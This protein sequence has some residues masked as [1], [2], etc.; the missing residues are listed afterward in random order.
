MKK[1]FII[2]LSL[3]L[4]SSSVG[5]AKSQPTSEESYL[6]NQSKANEFY[7]KLISWY[8]DQK[9][10]VEF[11]LFYGGCYLDDFGKLVIL[12]TEFTAENKQTIC[13]IIG[14][15]EVS[16]KKADYPYEHLKAAYRKTLALFGESFKDNDDV[17][18]LTKNISEAYIDEMN[19]RFVIGVISDTDGCLSIACNYI[20]D[21]GLLLIEKS[22]PIHASTSINPGAELVVASTYLYSAGFR[23]KY[24]KNGAT[25]Y[26]LVTAAHSNSIGDTVQKSNQSIGSI[27]LRQFSG[28]V[29]ASVVELNSNSSMTCTTEYGHHTLVGNHYIT[30]I[31]TN[32]LI[33]K[34]GR[35]TYH[36]SGYVKSSSC[37]CLYDGVLFS[38]YIR[39]DYSGDS[40]DSGG[41]VYTLFNGDYV[42]VGIHVAK[43]TI[44]GRTYCCQGDNIISNLGIIPY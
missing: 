32:T 25:K 18:Y 20:N 3:C 35:T 7:A 24:T 27:S 13:S 8:T 1:V 34:D 30:S 15:Q 16:F 28:T 40:G 26:G 4:L 38:D 41:L 19:N 29:D 6:Y 43:N 22:G 17:A 39:A 2:I 33:Y 9:Q 11:P 31:V 37:L 21:E 36:T 44:T 12:L 5:F 42:M 14:S 23:C 10:S